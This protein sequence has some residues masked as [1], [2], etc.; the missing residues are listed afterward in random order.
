MNSIY[1]IRIALALAFLYVVSDLTFGY[2]LESKTV[3]LVLLQTL[4]GWTGH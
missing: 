1:P 2:F 3:L 4:F